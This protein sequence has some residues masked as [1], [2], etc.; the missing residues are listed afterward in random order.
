MGVEELD[1]TYVH[2][3]QAKNAL[4]APVGGYAGG[5]LLQLPEPQEPASLELYRCSYDDVDDST[6]CLTNLSK[7]IG[8]RCQGCGSSMTTKMK[9]V[10]SSSG[11]GGVVAPATSTL[12]AAGFMQGI[13][14]YTVMDDLKVAPM[15]TISGITLL[16]TFGIT[17]I[18]MLQEKTV[19]LGYAEGLEILRV[20]LQSKTVLSDVFLVKK[21]KV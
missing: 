2:S 14:T 19:Q 8:T 9:L 21:Q 3:D 11:S 18:G 6:E 17:D 12:A 16:N 7:V 5:K 4:L 10:D 1:E 20:S 15:S 13:V